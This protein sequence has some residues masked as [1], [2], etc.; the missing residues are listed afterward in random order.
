MKYYKDNTERGP[1]LVLIIAFCV[2]LFLVNDAEAGNWYLEAGAAYAFNTPWG[3]SMNDKHY[4]WKGSNP[5]AILGAGYEH[6]GF[7]VGY[8]HLSNYRTG[9]P[10][11]KKGETGLD[12]V[13][14][15]YKWRF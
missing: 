2:A 5:I 9:F 10:F 15:T 4:S 11:N 1:L 6:K 13:K 3:E 7:T 14:A 12:T 8:E